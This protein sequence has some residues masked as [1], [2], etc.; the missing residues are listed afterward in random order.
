MIRT[1]V[2]AL[3]LLSGTAMM[4]QEFRASLTG[5]VTDPSGAAVPGATVKATDSA[6]SSAN[7]AKANAGDVYT[8]PFMDPGVYAVEATAPGFQALKREAITLSVRQR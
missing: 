4:A 5:T 3:L 8:S 7:D 2:L 1:S 6:T